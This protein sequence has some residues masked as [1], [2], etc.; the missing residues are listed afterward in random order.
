MECPLDQQT[1]PSDKPTPTGSQSLS[2]LPRPRSWKIN[3]RTRTITSKQ[4]P[5]TNGEK[6]LG[7]GVPSANNTFELRLPYIFNHQ[8]CERVANGH[9]ID[10][11]L[12]KFEDGKAG[13]R[14][15]SD[16]FRSDGFNKE[17]RAVFLTSPPSSRVTVEIVCGE[18]ATIVEIKKADGVGLKDVLDKVHE[19]SKANDGSTATIQH[20]IMKIPRAILVTEEEKS[21]IERKGKV[22]MPKAEEDAGQWLPLTEATTQ[23]LLTLPYHGPMIEPL[24]TQPDPEEGELATKWG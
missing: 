1:H 7:T 6:L 5:L 11:L 8:V 10:H 17:R 18:E 15:H 22:T 2:D 24:Y 19:L 21:E 23:P 9:G 12:D 4:E 3:H 16:L 13:L 20:A 14:I